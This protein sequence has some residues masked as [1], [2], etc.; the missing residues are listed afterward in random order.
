M[1]RNAVSG[2]ATSVRC[3]SRFGSL[4]PQVLR[5]GGLEECQEAGLMLGALT[6]TFGVVH[7]CAPSKHLLIMW[8]TTHGDQAAS[9]RAPTAARLRRWAKAMFRLHRGRRPALAIP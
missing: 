8:G 6:G 1:T 2:F 4:M 7:L 3:M 5:G 9:R